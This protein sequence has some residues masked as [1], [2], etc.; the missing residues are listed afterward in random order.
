MDFLLLSTRKIMLKKPKK[1]NSILENKSS[2]KK[3]LYKNYNFLLLGFIFLNLAFV[4]ILNA[5]VDPYDIFPKRSGESLFTKKPDKENRLRL[6]KY[7]NISYVRP[8]VLFLGSSR[9]QSGMKIAEANLGKTQTVYNLGIPGA[10]INELKYYL[11][12]AIAT[13]PDLKR[14]ILGIDFF[15]FITQV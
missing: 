3:T 11:E 14:V 1:K 10:N 12:Y 15:M 6:S 2:S 9:I 7:L 13:N 4:F 5:F 8:N